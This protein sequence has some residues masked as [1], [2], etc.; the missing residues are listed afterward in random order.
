MNR[1]VTSRI[2]AAALLGILFGSYVRHD[3]RKWSQRGREQFLAFEGARFDRYMSTPK[4]TPV[5]LF[6]FMIASLVG[7]GFY[8]LIVLVLYVFF[9]MTKWWPE[10]RISQQ[11]ATG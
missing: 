5:I 8:E 3:Y 7:F 4:P 11:I 6:G 10:D 9:K 2:L 1:R